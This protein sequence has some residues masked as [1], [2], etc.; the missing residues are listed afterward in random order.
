MTELKDRVNEEITIM[1]S[2]IKS[3]GYLYIDEA[4]SEQLISL[5]KDQQSRI[6]ELE[7]INKELLADI[8][9]YGKWIE[10]ALFDS[11]HVAPLEAVK[12]MFYYPNAPWNNPAWDWDVSHKDYA[13]EFKAAI[14]ITKGNI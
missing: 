13:G 12:M 9:F 11:K 10:R 4:K 6:D 1:E 5:I 7:A 8:S 2:A 14:D 3:L